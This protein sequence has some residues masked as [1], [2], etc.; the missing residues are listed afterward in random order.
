MQKQKSNYQATRSESRELVSPVLSSGGGVIVL[1]HKTEISKLSSENKQA[2][3]PF[4]KELHS[5]ILL[6]LMKTRFMFW[7]SRYFLIQPHNLKFLLIGDALNM[8]LFWKGVEQTK[9]QTNGEVW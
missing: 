8:K 9:N 2:N 7:D 6:F 5:L 4:S 3:R 1:E